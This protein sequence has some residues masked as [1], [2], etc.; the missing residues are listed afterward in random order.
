MRK[1]RIS[2]VERLQRIRRSDIMEKVLRKPSSIE[3]FLVFQGIL[4]VFKLIGVLTFNWSLILAP[5]WIIVGTFIVT[6][7]IAFIIGMCLKK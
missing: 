2:K 5:T 3:A 1:E 7:F 4:I 6:A